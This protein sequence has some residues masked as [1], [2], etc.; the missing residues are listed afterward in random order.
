M[1]DV[2]LGRKIFTGVNAVKLDTT[3]GNTKLFPN[4]IIGEP[5]NY[6][7][8]AS[9]WDGH[10][11]GINMSGYTIGEHGVAIG[12]PTESSTVNAQEVIKAALTLPWSRTY[13]ND[14]ATGVQMN[15]S[16]VNIPSTDV[17]IAIFGLV[18][19]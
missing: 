2:K 16:A 11:Y 5:I 4:Y 12:L 8:N 14:T 6:T 15:I 17:T 9:D 19:I 13:S 1:A 18:V 3:D 10:T 7:L